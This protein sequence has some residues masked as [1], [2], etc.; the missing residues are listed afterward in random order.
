MKKTPAQE[1]R[2]IFKTI[3]LT[4]KRARAERARDIRRVKLQIKYSKEELHD[5]L[6]GPIKPYSVGEYVPV[7]PGDPRYEDAEYVMNP[8]DLSGKWSF[9]IPR[10]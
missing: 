7:S 10:K 6:H 1:T 5:L 2:Y 3:P 8:I 4:A 9:K